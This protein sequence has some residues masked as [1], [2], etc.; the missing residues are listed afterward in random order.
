M[1]SVVGLL[2][3]IREVGRILKGGCRNSTTKMRRTRIK[4]IAISKALYFRKYTSI[5]DWYRLLCFRNN[6]IYPSWA[7][8]TCA[9]KQLGLESPFLVS[10]FALFHP[11]KMLIYVNCL[12]LS[13]APVRSREVSSIRR[14]VSRDPELGF[15]RRIRV[16]AEWISKYIRQN[17][18]LARS[19]NQILG[20]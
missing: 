4:A 18:N 7:S 17:R 3:W 5:A 1:N 9:Q 6:S 8:E 10:S 20:L 14:N 19:H 12:L 13:K 2:V 15:N 11:F 16:W